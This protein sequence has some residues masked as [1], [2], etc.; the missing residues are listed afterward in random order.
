MSVDQGSKGTQE[1]LAT[2]SAMTE[3]ANICSTALI[4]L[5]SKYDLL[6]TVVCTNGNWR[7]SSE[8]LVVLLLYSKLPNS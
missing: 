8:P 7:K 6:I 5:T 4:V 3:A 2:I 1:E